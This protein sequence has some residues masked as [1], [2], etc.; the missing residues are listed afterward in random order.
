MTARE[1]PDEKAFEGAR[2]QVAERLRNE[3]EAQVVSR[4]LEGLRKDAEIERNLSLLGSA[5]AA[6]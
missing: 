6:Q 5:A 2:D 4:W 3:K 1:T